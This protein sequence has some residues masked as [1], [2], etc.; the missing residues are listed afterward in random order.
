MTRLQTT[1][2]QIAF[3]TWFMHHSQND[4][5]IKLFV[6]CSLSLTELYRNAYKNPVKTH[7]HAPHH[8]VKLRAASSC[9]STTSDMGR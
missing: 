2:I 5:P 8:S 1:H 4:H 3:Y 7:C 6:Y 9:N